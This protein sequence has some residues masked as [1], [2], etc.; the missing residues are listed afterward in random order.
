MGHLALSDAKAAWEDEDY[1]DYEDAMNKYHDADI[2][3]G[4]A[5]VLGFAAV[6]FIGLGLLFSTH[7]PLN[8]ESE[9]K[10]IIM[11]GVGAI[12]L[13]AL[14]M[15][16]SDIIWN[17]AWEGSDHEDF[18]DGMLLRD[19]VAIFGGIFIF[20]GVGIIGLAKSDLFDIILVKGPRASYK[21][22]YNCRGQ[23]IRDSLF[24]THCGK[25][26]FTNCIQC[27][28]QIPIENINCGFCGADQT[29][30]QEEV[31]EAEEV[32]EI[33]DAEN[34]VEPEKKTEIEEVEKIS[35]KYVIEYKCPNCKEEFHVQ[36]AYSN[37]RAKCP[38]CLTKVMPSHVR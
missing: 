21:Y 24:C 3:W 26:Q 17:N 31:V 12:F 23:I 36:T 27:R 5:R 11:M 29:L 22:C 13:G 34:I 4:I 7:R 19:W 30:V 33:K 6:G 1:D 14:L 18:L 10:K 2:V 35:T 28:N 37:F 20:G 8:M 16:A 15:L 38:S 25:I 32:E 9:R